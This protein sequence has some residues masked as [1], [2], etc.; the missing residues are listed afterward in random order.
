MGFIQRDIN[1]NLIV[2]IHTT[3]SYA[4]DYTAVSTALMWKLAAIFD[5][6]E[7]HRAR[8]GVAKWYITVRV[9]FVKTV[10]NL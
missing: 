1:R 8:L 4:T 9:T 7:T 5:E 6:L 10:N 2:A 3:K